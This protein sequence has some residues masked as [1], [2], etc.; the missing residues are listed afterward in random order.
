MDDADRVFK[1]LGDPT[2]RRLLDLLFLRDGQTL[3]ELEQ[4]FARH[5]PLRHQQAPRRAG[6]CRAHHDPQGW[7]QQAPLPQPRARSAHPRPLG[8][9]RG[10]A[11]A[12]AD[13]KT[14]LES[15]ACRI[16]I[17]AP[18]ERVRRAIADLGPTV[19]EVAPG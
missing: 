19:R 7:P 18:V 3:T 5:E 11:E 6:G 13:L 12:L 2:R 16:F 9:Q 15:E 10:R 8:Q 1:A 14:A 17:R 4:V